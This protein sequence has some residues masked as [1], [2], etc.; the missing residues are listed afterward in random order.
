MSKAELKAIINDATIR[1]QTYEE[2]PA[3]T[4]DQKAQKAELEARLIAA[5]ASL[6]ELVMN[7]DESPA[8]ATTDS[9][10]LFLESNLLCHHLSTKTQIKYDRHQIRT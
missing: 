7:D 3:T 6:L 8:V 4:E 10:A 9:S 1:L 2:R 5:K